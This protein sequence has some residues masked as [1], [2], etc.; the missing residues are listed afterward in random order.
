MSLH[1]NAGFLRI[2]FAK[3]RAEMFFYPFSADSLLD[4][5]AG[6]I[7]YD[8]S[9]RTRPEIASFERHVG[10]ERID[11]L[12]VQAFDIP[13]T[14]GSS[15]TREQASSLRDEFERYVV[16]WFQCKPVP[17]AI[18]RSARSAIGGPA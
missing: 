3:S 10:D 17:N 16:I 8:Q 1:N 18:Q 9:R 5:S 15:M 13:P 12:V 2:G 6:L 7:R 4:S 11:E 14:V